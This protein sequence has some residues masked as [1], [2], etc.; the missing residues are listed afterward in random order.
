MRNA[1]RI[2]RDSLTSFETFDSL[3]G[4]DR[5]PSAVVPIVVDLVDAAL[6]RVAG[7]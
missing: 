5:T 6:E 3:A 4:S 7:R 1:L 2:P